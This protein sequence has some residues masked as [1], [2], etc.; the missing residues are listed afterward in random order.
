MASKVADLANKVLAKA[1]G[2]LAWVL[3]KAR[4]LASRA[5]ETAKSWASKALE[6]AKSWASKAFDAA[7]NAASKAWD[8]AKSLAARAWDTAKDWASRAWETAKSW[9]SKAISTAEMWASKAWVT[10][11]SLAGKAWDTAKTWAGKAWDFTKTWAGKAWDTIQEY[12]G[13]VW[14]IAKSIGGKAW[15][16]AKTFGGKAMGF[17]KSMAARGWN[18]VKNQ[19]QKA[20]ETAKKAKN[21][22]MKRLQ[23]AFDIAKSAGKYLLQ[24]LIAGTPAGIPIVAIDAAIKTVACVTG[25]GAGDFSFAGLVDKVL[26][27][28]P[29]IRS[30]VE[31]V[32][33]PDA[34]LMPM[35]AG[36]AG[37]L[38][39]EMPAK[40]LDAGRQQLQQRGGAAKATAT[41]ALAGAGRA[42]PASTVR[43]S[44]PAKATAAQTRTTTTASEI[45]SGFVRQITAK[46]AA[47]NVW[48]MVKDMFWTLLWPWPAIGKELSGL[49]SDVK[50]SISSL[51]AVR[52]VI[53]DPLG[54]LHDLWTNLLHLLDIPLA[55]WRRVNNIA[56]DLMGWVTI[57]LVVLGAVGGSTAGGVIGGILGGLASAGVALPAGAAAG[58]GA[59]GGAGALA[60]FAAAMGIGE[61][62]L[63]SFVSAEATNIGKKV[64]DLFTGELTAE[65]KEN[66][67][68]QIG[69]SLIGIG[70]AGALVLLSWIGSKLASAIKGVVQRIRGPR[71]EG[72]DVRP[73]D[74]K[75]D[76][77][78]STGKKIAAEEPTPDGH[79]IKVT[80]DGEVLFCTNPCPRLRTEFADVINDPNPRFDKIR[81]DLDAADKIVDPTAKAIAEVEIEKRLA[82]ARLWR[83]LSVERGKSTPGTQSEADSVLQA[84]QEGRIT[85]LGELDRPS[86]AAGESDHDFVFRDKR[87]RVAGYVEI[88]TA[89]DPSRFPTPP[90]RGI[91]LTEQA[92]NVANDVLHY[93]KDVQVVIDLKNLSATDKVTYLAELQ[94]KGLSLSPPVTVLNR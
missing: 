24:V 4:D 16:Y 47:V 88:K 44:A 48:Q 14:S 91:P 40:A 75:P 17:A 81:T 90:P 21:A 2:L 15:D 22:L 23:S 80:D 33:N 86:R 37:K 83:R 94:K 64:L 18:W 30:V 34:T 59:G 62:L 26:K 20:L 43:R 38:E 32:K 42:V 79:K 27:F 60:G 57:A 67:Y 19:G 85:S 55:I 39:R 35:V 70:V 29:F 69:D 54:A 89:I 25:K 7:K 9:G 6:T 77:D 72:P 84:L 93:G 53:D 78:P 3:N 92:A 13:K 31:A 58:A 87:G 5:L 82:E 61:V 28:A 10:A 46:W 71:A 56:S 51:F 50:E 49:W 73:P 41:H 45:W 1:S 65:E 74:G 36:I 63:A 11:K 66:E 12:S 8:A 52:N 68:S 76:V